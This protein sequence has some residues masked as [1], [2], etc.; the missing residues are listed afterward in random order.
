MKKYF[1]KKNKKLKNV[2][3]QEVLLDNLSKKNKEKWGSPEKRIE[4]PLLKIILN[5]FFWFSFLVIFVLLMGSFYLQVVKGDEFL[6]KSNENK[7]ISSKIQAERGKIYDKN[8]NQLVYNIPIFN[9]VCYKSQLSNSEDESI[10]EV[11]LILG[12][13]QDDILSTVQE[14]DKEKIIIKEDLNHHQLIVLETKIKDLKGFE[15]EEKLYREYRDGEI[16]SHLIGYTGKIEKNELTQKSDFYSFSDYIGKTGLEKYY[17]EYLRKIPGQQRIEKDV[18]G[19]V[20]SE[21]IISLPE[22]GNNLVLY[23]DYDLQKKITEIVQEKLKE[24]NSS[25]AVVIAMDPNTGG[26]LSLV[27]LP[28]FDNNAFSQSKDEEIEQILNSSL[29]PLFNRAISG[30]GYPTGSVIKPLIAAAALEERVIESDRYVNCQG[31]IEV[32]HEYDEDIVY[33][34][35][36]WEVHGYT[37]MRKA[38]AESC[39]VYFYS[40]GGGNKDLDIDGLG[41]L[42]IKKYLELFGWGQK[43]GI[44]LPDEGGSVLPT[45][46]RDWRLGNTYHFSIG[47]GSFSILPIQVVTAYS[48][49]ANG[50]EL[51]KPQI[52]QKIVDSTNGEIVKVFSKE[53]IR[54]N[55]ISEE[56][57]EVVKE[58]MRQTVTGENSPLASAV[59][60]SNL[61]VKAAA[62]TGTAQVNVDG[63]IYNNWVSVFAP[64]ENPEIV[65][66]VLFEGVVG[67][68]AVVVPTAQE[69]LNWYF[70][71]QLKNIQ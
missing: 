45:I 27:S 6:Q 12:K 8:L 14:S 28:S 10:G 26:I 69:I 53:V 21:E 20:F 35:H 51:I 15:I 40:I 25:K 56:N 59:F 50:G 11:A 67:E 1:V 3:P 32:E 68:R 71:K 37:D 7:Y 64:F 17:E 62:K 49:I 22:S 60:L 29:D 63:E 16:F 23:L 57:I 54:K 42:N 66:T 48:A 38:I 4:T 44:D 52:V 24:I 31:L 9:L 2:E 5:K 30:I 61:P 33:R 18:T 47:Q 34:Y 55:F 39:N 13:N 65:L 70:T 58:G 41:P 43:T 19:N 36:D 46:D